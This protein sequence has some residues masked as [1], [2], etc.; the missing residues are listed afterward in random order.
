VSSAGEE[1]VEF[2]TSIGL[3][4]DD[5]QSYVVRESLGERRDGKYSAFEVGL[6]VPRQNGKGA[7]LEAREL[8]GLFLFGEG[9]ILHSA[10]EFKTA[11]EAFRRVLA[12]V[13]NAPDLRKRV[14]RVRTSHG[15]EGIELKTGARLRFVARS[16]G[17]GRG[18][19]GDTVILDEAYNLASDGM[20]ALLPTLSARPN[21]QIWYTSSAG[22]ST[23]DQLRRVRERGLAGEGKRLAYFEWSAP[24]DVSLDSREAWAQANP[25]LGIRITEEFVESERDAMDDTA[26]ARERLGV[27]FDPSAQMVIDGARWAE[28]ADPES[29][30]VDPVVFAVDANPERSGAAIAVAGRRQDGHGHVEVVD[31]RHGTGWVVERIVELHR[32]HK[33]R[34]WVLDPASA[35]G[36][37]I[38][39]LQERGIEPVLITGR[40]MAQACGALYEDVVENAALRHLDQPQ[41]NAALSGARKRPLGDAWAWHR[42]NSDID[43]SPLVAVTL[44]WHGMATH[45]AP[46]PRSAYEDDDLVVV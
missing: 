11:Q 33:P 22:M 35:A 31:S 3:K 19:S 5:W 32:R 36:A 1:A 27:W 23:S 26:F 17:S 12:H 29:R 7:I 16:T 21:P 44:A 34:A 46:A 8:A 6:L 2:C 30:V 20:A 41:L 24:A 43:I 14:A 10:H 9:L 40:E 25:A 13:E 28:L 18:F 42:R 15:E 4:L 45:G 39:A 38:P 37:W